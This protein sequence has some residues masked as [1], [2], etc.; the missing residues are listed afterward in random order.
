MRHLVAVV[1]PFLVIFGATHSAVAAAPDTFKDCD[2]CPEMV[3]IPAG[4]F[5]MGSPSDEEGRD[6]DEGPVH[7]VQVP[8]F[9]LG[10]YEVTRGQFAAFVRATGYSAGGNCWVD[11]GGGDLRELASKNWRDPNFSQTDRDPVVCVNWNEAK[12]YVE[13]L[14]RETGERYRLPSESEWEYAARAGTTAARY[15]GNDPDAACTNANVAD[16]FAKQNYSG[17]VHNYSGFTIHN[18]RDGHVYTAAVGSFRANGFG[19]Y[20]VLGNVWEWVEDCWIGSYVGA[21]SNGD[22]WT[23]G[24][25]DRRD[26]RGG[27]WYDH[28]GFVRAANR[29]RHGP[30][31][32]LTFTG[33]RV[34]R[35]LP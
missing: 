24:D 2:V 20:D 10:K 21:L 16:E 13:W 25:C 35:T 11:K 34:A 17:F 31:I 33:F 28:P 26:V 30:V 15:W 22:S 23:T 3:V 18:C 19:L 5:M 4:Q 29:W 7:R 14:G 1:A 32:R 27:S 6:V 8:S 9:A 12:A